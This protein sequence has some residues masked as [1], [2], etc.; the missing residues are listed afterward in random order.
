MRIAE[1]ASAT[2]DLPVPER[3]RQ[4]Q[5]A[6]ATCPRWNEIK[7]GEVRRRCEMAVPI[8]RR[9]ALLR[10]P[11]LLTWGK[12]QFLHCG[13]TGPNCISNHVSGYDEFDAAILLPPSRR[14]IGSDWL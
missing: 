11:I 8:F 6:P 10:S 7:R 12:R 14:V 4:G 3:F 1:R 5:V 9:L 2:E 13:W